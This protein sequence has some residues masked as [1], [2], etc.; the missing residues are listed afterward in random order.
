MTKALEGIRIVDRAST[1]PGL[2]HAAPRVAR[3][4]GSESR[5]GG[6]VGPE[7]A[8][9]G[10]GARIPSVGLAT[11]RV[12]VAYMGVQFGSA[13]TTSWPRASRQRAT[14]SLLVDA[15]ITIGSRDWVPSTAAK[16]SGSVRMRCSI[17]S[18]PS[19][20]M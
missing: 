8:R 17:T 3:R 1:K 15:S 11:L 4:W 16:R 5:L 18:P 2:V 12:R 19:A 14:H 13:T 10:Q 6:A 9:L 7:Q 20:R